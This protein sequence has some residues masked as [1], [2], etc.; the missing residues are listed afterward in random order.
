[1]IHQEVA[2]DIIALNQRGYSHRKIARRLGLHRET[3]ERY[4]ADP[5][6]AFQKQ[7]RKPRAG[8][9]DAYRETVKGWLEEDPDYQATT[10]YD[11]LTAMGFRGSYDIVKRLVKSIKGERQ[12]IAYIRFETEPGR[13][14][15]VDFGQFD[16]DNPDGSTTTLYLFTM[17]LGYSRKLYG[18]LVSRCNLSSFLDCHIRAF[19]ALGGVPQ[20]L[21]YDR[22][23][24]VFVFEREGTKYFTTA[25]LGF[26]N[27]YGFKPD[28]TPPRAPWVKGKIERP[29]PFIREGF[30]R[31]YRFTTVEQANQDLGAWLT[32][33]EDRI[34]GTTHERIS[35][36]A[37]RELPFL[38]PFPQ[39]DMDT[40]ERLFRR[41]AKDCTVQLEGNWY[42]VDHRLVGR[43][44]L[45]RLKNEQI[46]IFNDADLV[47]TYPVAPGKGH[48]VADPRFYDALR[49]DRLMNQRKYAAITRTKGRALKTISPR[50]DYD[51][52]VQ[53][54][55]AGW[56]DQLVSEVPA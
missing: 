19:H 9:L 39:H 50:A 17:I 5:G 24:N 2:V 35:D 4:L 52:E 18:E 31:G 13:Q 56:Y 3:V 20:E 14:A 53:I 36:R 7:P 38:S 8:K 54:R 43:T 28:V 10:L 23:K 34:H 37:T 30:W 29:Y 1:M 42:V 47:V 27:H 41:V 32:G 12:K 15:Q 40:S 33:K 55:P 44:V 26:A 6:I 51:I 49:K 11:R 22:M 46:R 16:V 25:M 48:L 21:L 45:L